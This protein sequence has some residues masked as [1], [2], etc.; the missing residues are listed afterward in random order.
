MAYAAEEILDYF[1]KIAPCFNE[2]VVEDIGIS[3]I[4]DGMYLAYSP[5]ESLDLK[6]R[7]GDPVKGKVSLDCLA[8]G[9]KT[10]SL[11]SK[12]K[13]AYGV[14]YI[15][16]AYP[17][18]EG[19]RTVGCITTTQTIETYEVI[20]ATAEHLAAS[21]EEMSAGLEEV[22]ARSQEL[23]RVSAGL[24]DLGK[25]LVDT[26]RQTDEIVTFIKTIA[27]QT[28]LLGLNAAIE[29]ARVGEQG[30]G[31]GVVAEEVRKLAAA[32]ADSVKSINDSLLT[33]KTVADSFGDKISVIDSN[34]DQQSG[35]ISELATASQHL[36]TAATQLAEIAQKYFRQTS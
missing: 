29:A 25:K 19:D 2:V 27:G 13:S 3:V 7:P 36:A 17:V 18:R 8:T 22:S 33:I 26:S 5:A 23:S 20:K 12:E 16:C 24:G 1:A 21:S 9:R 32:T 4:K 14:P 11:V 30:R 10:V 31:F 6:N 15:A 34:I 35:S 28:N